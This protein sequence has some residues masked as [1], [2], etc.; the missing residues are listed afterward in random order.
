MISINITNTTEVDE[1]GGVKYVLMFLADYVPYITFYIVGT[2][3]GVLG[4]SIVIYFKFLNL[5]F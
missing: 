4:E 2:I 3:V 1:I 5:N